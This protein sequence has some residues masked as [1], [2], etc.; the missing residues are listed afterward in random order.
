MKALFYKQVRLVSH[1]MTWVF[2]LFGVMFLIPSY[3]YTVAF[4][5][6]TLGLFFSFMNGRE[7][8]DT[9]F[10]ALLPVRK[11]DTVRVSVWFTVVIE[12]LSLVIGI[13]FA[14]LSARINPVGT[15][16][17]GLDCNAALFA[18][19]LV[20]F[21]VFNGVFF[22]MFYRTGYKVGVSYLKTMIPLALIMLLCEALPHFPALAWLNDTSAA[23]NVRQLPLLAAG[24]AIFAIVTWLGCRR[25][26]ARYE[27]V[28][29]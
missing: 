26:M 13:P 23:G 19:G 10:T 16:A 3:P 6:V 15:N 2:C 9:D 17:V 18:A 29:L 5:Y 27:K 4:F 21:A 7:Q 12:L 8:R 28:D 25:A 20:V 24:A 11:R 22:P 14:C 1:P